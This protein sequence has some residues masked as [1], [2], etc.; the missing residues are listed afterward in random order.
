MSDDYDYDSHR[1]ALGAIQEQEGRGLAQEADSDLDRD[2]RKGMSVSAV[3]KEKRN[4]RFLSDAD[5]H[6]WLTE[7]ANGQSHATTHEQSLAKWVGEADAMKLHSFCKWRDMWQKQLTPWKFQQ[8]VK[9]C[10]E[11]LEKFERRVNNEA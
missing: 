2:A 6:D 7:D 5:V 11:I 4:G 1:K 9:E 10:N 3:V 8:K